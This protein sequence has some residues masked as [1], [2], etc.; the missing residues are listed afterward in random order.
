MIVQVRNTTLAT[1]VIGALLAG[2]LAASASAHH[3]VGPSP[4]Q[5]YVNPSTGYASPSSGSASGSEAAA[6]VASE[7]PEAA[8]EAAS[9][10]S[11]LDWPSAGIGA[12]AGAALLLIVVAATSMGRPRRGQMFRRRAART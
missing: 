6:S 8:V 4:D 7:E 2:A 11:G 9:S 5:I 1:I 10:P 12:A 3:G